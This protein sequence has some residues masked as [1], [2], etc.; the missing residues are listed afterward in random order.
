MVTILMKGEEVEISKILKDVIGN[1]QEF[2]K[3]KF[4]YGDGE[5]YIVQIWDF[6]VNKKGTDYGNS[7]ERLS[8]AGVLEKVTEVQK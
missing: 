5:Y 1:R 6:V 2:G 4:V 8:T 3:S 7:L